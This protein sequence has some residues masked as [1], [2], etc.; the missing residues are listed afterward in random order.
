MRC[1]SPRVAW[2][3]QIIITRPSA[4]RCYH[5]SRVK[6]Q[7]AKGKR[8]K[9]HHPLSVV[10]FRAVSSPA[11]RH[12]VEVAPG[13]G[14]SVHPPLRHGT[15]VWKGKPARQGW[16]IMGFEGAQA[17]PERTSAPPHRQKH[18]LK[19][20]KK[21]CKL[22]CDTMIEQKYGYLRLNLGK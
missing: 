7:K 8:T 3:K 4:V 12:H 21:L 9:S 5:G 20:K 19:L 11:H 10:R 13:K 15:P 2:S 1:E 22:H 16:R 18:P 14:A 17:P 6:H